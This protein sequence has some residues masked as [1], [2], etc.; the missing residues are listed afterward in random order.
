VKRS[1][2]VDEA[3]K[4]TYALLATAAAKKAMSRVEWDDIPG[5]DRWMVAV[6]RWL[7]KAGA[8]ATSWHYSKPKP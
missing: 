2:K 5:A 4:S 6:T 7:E 3:V 1:N 8:N